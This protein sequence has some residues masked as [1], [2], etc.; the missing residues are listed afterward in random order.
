QMRAPEGTLISF[1]TQ[2]GNTALDGDGNSPYTRAL[3]ATIRK[4]GLDIF[5]T[6][7]EVGLAVKRSTGGAQ[8]PWVSSSPIDGNFY[9]VPPSPSAQV[10][11][12][13]PPEARLA[14]PA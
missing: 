13:S 7:N 12:A 4:K 8:Q 10:A 14:S 5:Q 3:S 11:V 2:P 6:F 9:F 1:A